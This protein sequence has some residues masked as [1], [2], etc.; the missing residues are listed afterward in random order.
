V[1]SAYHYITEADT[2][3]PY[4][5]LVALLERNGIAGR[6]RDLVLCGQVAIECPPSQL[7]VALRGA[8]PIVCAADVPE[9]VASESDTAYAVRVA[10]EIEARRAS[11]EHLPAGASPGPVPPPPAAH[12]RDAG[13]QVAE[14]M[15]AGREGR[16][17]AAWATRPLQQQAPGLTADSLMPREGES[18]T[19]FAKRL[20]STWPGF[21]KGS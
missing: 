19:A 18:Q 15:R 10:A 9:R 5:E 13:D 11:A 21:Q 14:L 1:T 6:G 2:H 17:P 8:A 3:L 4:A 7:R 12:G 16:K 20:V